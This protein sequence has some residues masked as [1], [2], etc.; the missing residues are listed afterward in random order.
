MFLPKFAPDQIAS[1]LAIHFEGEPV[2]KPVPSVR[3]KVSISSGNPIA[4][5]DL[6]TDGDVNTKW[7]ASFGQT[8]ISLDIDL[9]KP[10]TIQSVS[11]D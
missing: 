8:K 7:Q 11:G 3:K 5:T 1:V 9:E 4:E 10:V 6:L 2:V